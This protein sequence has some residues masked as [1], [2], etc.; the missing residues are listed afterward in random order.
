MV[1]YDP[2]FCIYDMAWAVIQSL[3]NGVRALRCPGSPFTGNRGFQ[4]EAGC[5]MNID[6][7]LTFYLGQLDKSNL[8]TYIFW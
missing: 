1:K 5:E 7:F 4:G 3:L 6:L 8:H 2:I